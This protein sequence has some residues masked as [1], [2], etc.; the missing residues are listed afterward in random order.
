MALSPSPPTAG[1]SHLSFQVRPAQTLPLLNV[2]S[3][4]CLRSYKG[5]CPTQE[6]CC[7]LLEDPTEKCAF[8]RHMSKTWGA[9]RDAELLLPPL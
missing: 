8:V 5:E 2:G 1:R 7:M 6:A 9:S 4:G 3:G